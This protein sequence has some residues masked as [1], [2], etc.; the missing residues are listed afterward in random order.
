MKMLRRQTILMNPITILMS[1]RM[2]RTQDP[3]MFRLL[4]RT[5]TVN[6]QQVIKF[7]NI[8]KLLIGMVKG[9]FP[10]AEKTLI[11]VEPGILEAF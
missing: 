2:T 1:L 8:R 6:L 5:I 9:S 4:Q 10:P 7:P 11:V 3:Q